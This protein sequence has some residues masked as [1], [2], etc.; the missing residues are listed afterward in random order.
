[1]QLQVCAQNNTQYCQATRPGCSVQRGRRG[2]A[3]TANMRRLNYSST[4]QRLPIPTLVVCMST[5][6]VTSLKST[7]WLASASELQNRLCS[8]SA[9]ATQTPVRDYCACHP[10]VLQ[11]CAFIHATTRG[12]KPC[13]CHT[14]QL[15][16]KHHQHC[17]LHNVM[18]LKA[19]S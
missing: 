13:S 11:A 1:M 9:A 3:S 16:I 4:S 12:I 15:P 7:C 17:S 19:A 6:C 8:C 14:P 5:C 10:A 2:A 18:P